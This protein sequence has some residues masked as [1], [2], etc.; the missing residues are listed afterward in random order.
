MHKRFDVMH[1]EGTVYGLHLSHVRHWRYKTGNAPTIR[2]WMKGGI[3]LKFKGKI[4]S[5]MYARL[6][7]Q[8]MATKEEIERALERNR[9]NAR[10][11]HVK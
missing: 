8:H 5:K 10:K 4:A 2:L 1:V 6:L 7:A 11:A 9:Q 3:E